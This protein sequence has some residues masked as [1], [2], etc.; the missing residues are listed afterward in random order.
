MYYLS[1]KNDP[2]ARDE[3]ELVLGCSSVSL[4]GRIFIHYTYQPSTAKR[5]I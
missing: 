5:H 2:I 3:V 1:V 4:S